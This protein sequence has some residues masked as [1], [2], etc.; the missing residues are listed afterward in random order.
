MQQI[1]VLEHKSGIL[2]IT[3]RDTQLHINIALV[4]THVHVVS[5]YIW[6]CVC[7]HM[8]MHTHTLNDWHTGWP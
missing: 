1:I 8:H 7:V 6:E 5:R 4:H 3:Y 2:K